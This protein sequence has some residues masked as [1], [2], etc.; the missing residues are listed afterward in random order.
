MF[1]MG[2][3]M[4][5]RWRMREQG[6][7]PRWRRHCFGGAFLDNGVMTMYLT[8]TTERLDALAALNRLGVDGHA[9]GPDVQVRKGRWNFVQLYH[10]YRY[11]NQHLGNVAL[12]GS[13]IDQARNRLLYFVPTDGDKRK[14]EARLSAL[15][16]PCFL[17]AVEIRPYARVARERARARLAL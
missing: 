9:W 13:D 2:T 17:V 5:G 3:T 10:W 16:V 1:V 12:S 15:G 7:W 14:L 4:H 8:D 11:I 6:A